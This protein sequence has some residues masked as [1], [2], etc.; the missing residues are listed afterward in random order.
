MALVDDIKNMSVSELI[1]YFVFGVLLS[2]A[3]KLPDPNDYP[4]DGDDE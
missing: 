1:C 4:D 3:D 2:E